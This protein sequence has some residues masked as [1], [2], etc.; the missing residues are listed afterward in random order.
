MSNKID[1]I[2]DYIF[3]FNLV[4]PNDQRNRCWK[5]DSQNEANKIHTLMPLTMIVRDSFYILLNNCSLQIFT[6]KVKYACYED[7]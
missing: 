2:P 4:L 6:L 1:H 7:D 5:N 3:L